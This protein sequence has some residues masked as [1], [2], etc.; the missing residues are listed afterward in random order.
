M[1]SIS[2]YRPGNVAEAVEALAAGGKRAA[3]Y[4]GGSDILVRLKN[5]LLTAPDSLVDIK[6]VAELHFMDYDEQTGLRIGSMITLG[7]LMESAEARRYP[8]LLE[9]MASISSPELRNQSTVGGNL[10]QEV[11]CPYY[12]SNYKCWR[13]GG[14]MC[15]AEVGDNTEYQSIMGARR[16]YA[17]YP[18]DLA[19]TLVAL[20]AGVSVSGSAGER[21]LSVEELIPGE[22]EADGRIQSHVLRNDEVL[23]EV[24]I[25][26]PEAAA[27]CM[28][29]KV[30]KR[31]VWDFA[32]ASIA[33]HL[34]V[35]ADRIAAAR[36]VFGGIATRPWRDSR[37]EG[38]LSGKTFRDDL[39]DG[40]IQ[41]ALV[42]AKPLPHNGYKKDQAVGLLHSMLT[43]VAGRKR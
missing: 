34:S 6:G 43:E 22:V 42:D 15:Y 24:S 29:G 37:L 10:L 16:S 30:R 25:P 12:R 21:H 13:N 28:F 39:A 9:T 36:V 8:V 23:T 11:W 20:N 32:S 19:V 17:A 14:D 26:P 38:Y 7:E 35:E 1:K 18:G 4:A 41:E 3:V 5:R 31:D 33:L 2:I 40:A 27:I